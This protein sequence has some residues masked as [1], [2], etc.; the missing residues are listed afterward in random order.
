MPEAP[1]P[2]LSMFVV[3]IGLEARQPLAQQLWNRDPKSGRVVASR[4]YRP[5]CCWFD[6]FTGSLLGV[7]VL[8]LYSL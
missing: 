2:D 3:I 5:L 1:W 4:F 7:R 8:P 6:H